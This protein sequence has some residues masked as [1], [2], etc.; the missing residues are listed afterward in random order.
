MQLINDQPA[1]R[2]SRG[3]AGAVALLLLGGVMLA[4]CGS[5]ASS[6]SASTSSASTSTSSAGTSSAGA[7]AT[8]KITLTE[9]ALIPDVSSAS[10][11]AITFDVTNAGTMFTHE[12]VVIK[13][14]LAAA[15]LPVDAAGKVN[16]T[17]AGVANVGEIS[18]ILMG[19]NKSVSLTLQP[20]KYVLI[21]NIVEAAGGH[22]SHY[23][24][25]MRA[26][27]TVN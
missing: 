5:S 3:S 7:G 27:F 2:R 1:L 26:A 4:A 9:W 23:T 13:T 19:A 11:G 15:D 18:E 25:G 14:D 22:E 24:K 17:A 21:C 10:A 8:V 16:E 12:F 6:S 20:G